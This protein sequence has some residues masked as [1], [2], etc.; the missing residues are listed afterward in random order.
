MINRS[1]VLFVNSLISCICCYI[2]KFRTPACK[3]ICE[4]ICCCL[5]WICRLFYICRLS[6][7][8]IFC[9]CLKNG[10]S[11][12]IYKYN[13]VLILNCS[14]PAKVYVYSAVAAFSGSSGLTTSAA[15][16]P[17]LYSASLITVVP[18]SSTNV[19]LYILSF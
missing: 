6:S 8:F 13:A 12:L 17:Y 7:I 10:C 19:T 15:A 11:I 18:S 3:F 5:S 14:Q 2:C 4:F 1:F 16:V 9:C